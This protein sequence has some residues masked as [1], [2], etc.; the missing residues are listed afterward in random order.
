M[1]GSFANANT[2]LVTAFA[3]ANTWL[4]GPFAKANKFPRRRAALS[5]NLCHMRFRQ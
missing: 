3:K 1:V 4:V 5:A 2:L